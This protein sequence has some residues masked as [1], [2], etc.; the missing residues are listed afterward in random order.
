MRPE[1]CRCPM[2]RDQTHRTGGKDVPPDQPR[3]SEKTARGPPVPC[4]KANG[5]TGTQLPARQTRRYPSGPMRRGRTAEQIERRPSATCT[6]LQPPTRLQDA[7]SIPSAQRSDHREASTA[8]IHPSSK[9][10]RRPADARPP[11][12]GRWA[13]GEDT[14]GR[15]PTLGKTSSHPPLCA[16]IKPSRRSKHVRPTDEHR[17]K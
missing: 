13:K 15:L 12:E 6:R 11:R 5:Q 4:K 9:R 10:P 17:S 16:W 1:K 14:D 8:T 7:H 2:P 3:K